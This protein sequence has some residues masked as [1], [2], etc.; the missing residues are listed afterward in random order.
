[1]VFDVLDMLEWYRNRYPSIDAIVG[2]MDRSL[3]YDDEVGTYRVDGVDYTVQT[4]V[5]G[6]DSPIEEA[7]ADSMHIVLEGEELI[8]LEQDERPSAVMMATV[9]R[10]AIFSRGD[11]FKSRLQNGSPKAVKKVVFTLSA[12]R[13]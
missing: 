6:P 10:F 11:R 12:P 8:A 5:T 2:I 9:G 3:P 4:Y 1:M 13:P 7:V